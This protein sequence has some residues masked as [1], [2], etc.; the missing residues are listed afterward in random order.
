M[1][2]LTRQNVLDQRF[3][4]TGFGW[5]FTKMMGF[6][7]SLFEESLYLDADAIAWGNVG[8]R[9]FKNGYDFIVD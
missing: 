8:E 6:L 2:T 9:F 3:K 5:G 4:A 1:I 7:H